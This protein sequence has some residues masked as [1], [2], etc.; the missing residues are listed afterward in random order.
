[1]HPFRTDATFVRNSWYVACASE[2]LGSRPFERVILGQPIAFYRSGEG[3]AMAMFGIC[4]HRFYPLALHGKVT[5]DALVCNY[6]GFT[7][8]GRTGACIRVPSQRSVPNFQQR[9]YPVVERGPWVWIWPGDPSLADET[10]IPS[11]EEIGFGDGW[12]HIKPFSFLSIKAR[13]MLL[14]ENLMDLTHLGA[15]HGDMGEFDLYVQSA[16]E[17]EETAERLRIV[18]PMR[19]S[20]T[21]QHEVMFGAANR[22][23][24]LSNFASITTYYGPGYVTTTGHI[25][26]SIDS[27]PNVDKRIYGDVIFHH[28]VTPGTPNTCHYFGTSSRT[29]RL[30]DKA[31]DD[32]FY[33]FDEAVRRQ[34]IEAAEAIEAKMVQF[35]EPSVELMV[36]SDAAAG[37]IRR[38]MQR[39][40]DEETEASAM[41]A[42]V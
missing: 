2:D 30:S 4:P 41:S 28:A 26:Q 6:H 11:F 23:E 5:G 25:T 42:S 16:M 27:I 14:V 22:F 35:G 36:K 39:A 29:H 32:L 18:R 1:M 40:I 13:Y 12:T 21:Q 20:W 9:V 8:D 10:R 37:R 24:G 3:K 7:Y 34:D 38:K 33:P 19:D 15:L 31:F 17:I